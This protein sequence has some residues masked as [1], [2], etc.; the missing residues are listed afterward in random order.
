MMPC[1]T[2]SMP[3]QQQPCLRRSWKRRK[4]FLRS[5]FWSIVHHPNFSFFL[6]FFA[7]SPPPPPSPAP[8]PGL[9]IRIE[10]A[11][12]KG[13]SRRKV[14]QKGRNPKS[15]IHNKPETFSKFKWL[16]KAVHFICL[17]HQTLNSVRH[18]ITD[19]AQASFLVGDTRA[20]FKYY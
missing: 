1:T 19:L 15:F 16:Q 20:L 4:I 13:R 7:A 6:F 17:L 2:H 3:Q 12:R 14:D 11:E 5:L 18:R 8:E 10:K 9:R